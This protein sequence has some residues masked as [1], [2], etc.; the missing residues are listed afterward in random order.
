MAMK[1]IAVL[2]ALAA[3]SSTDAFEISSMSAKEVKVRYLLMQSLEWSLETAHKLPTVQIQ[4]SDA[5]LD[6]S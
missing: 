1:T 3:A 6:F 4:N 5:Y 2:L